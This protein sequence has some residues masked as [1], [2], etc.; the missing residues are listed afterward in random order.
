MTGHEIRRDRHLGTVVHIVAGRQNRPNLPSSDCPFCP[1]GLEAP[2]PYVT[3]AFPNRWPALGEGR[4][5]V[6][7]YSPDHDTNLAALGPEGVRKVIDMWADRTTALLADP[8]VDFVLVFENRGR[9][10]GATIDHP[11]CQ[12]YAFDHVPAR[13]RRLIDASWSPEPDPDERIV[14]THGT[15]RAWIHDAPVHPVS[16]V[17]APVERTADLQS[18]DARSRED[19]AHVLSDV[20]SRCDAMFGDAMPYMM[21]VNQAPR[22]EP[23]AWLHLEIVSPWR[24]TGLPRY[25]AAAEVAT[26]EYFNPVDPLELA[27]R[28]NSMPR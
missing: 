15:W 14:S 9:S 8:D 2:E 21:W 5:E 22:S 11:H 19:L 27:S 1:G 6:V 28:L 10:V 7:L 20:L 16:I 18:L 25:I 3:R 4:C 26:E 23:S 17:L 12:I 13:Q 24:A